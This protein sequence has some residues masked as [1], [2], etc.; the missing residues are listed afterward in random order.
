MKR[1]LG[2]MTDIDADN[3]AEIRTFRILCDDFSSVLSV[4][5]NGRDLQLTQVHRFSEHTT[6]LKI[7]RRLDYA[8]RPRLSQ[9]V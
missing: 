2:D 5:G 1:S 8:I 7:Q 6:I 3:L 4:R 9:R